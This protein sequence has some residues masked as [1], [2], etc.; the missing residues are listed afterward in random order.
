MHEMKLPKTL[1]STYWNF[2][3]LCLIRY[4]GSMSSAGSLKRLHVIFSGRVQGVGFRYTVTE[5]ATRF[6]VT[7]LVRNLRDG[8]VELI[9]EGNEEEL[10]D[11]LN[12][13]RGSRLKRNIINERIDW[14][15]ASDSFERFGIE[16]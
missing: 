11:F 9:A 3:L 14:K 4:K 1:F 16:L 10:V 2:S 5:L 12:Q 15:P 13:I 6:R 7:G 8:D